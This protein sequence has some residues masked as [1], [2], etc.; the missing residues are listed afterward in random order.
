[1]ESVRDLHLETELL[2]I[3]YRGSSR[4]PGRF[5]ARET[6]RHMRKPSALPKLPAPGEL[7]DVGPANLVMPSNQEARV[8]FSYGGIEVRLQLLTRHHGYRVT[9]RRRG[10]A[11]EKP[12]E[13]PLGAFSPPFVITDGGHVLGSSPMKRDRRISLAPRRGYALRWA[14]EETSP[15]IMTADE[16]VLKLQRDPLRHLYEASVAAPPG[17]GTLDVYVGRM[18]A[19]IDGP[20]LEGGAPMRQVARVREPG[21]YLRLTSAGGSWQLKTLTLDRGRESLDIKGARMF[22]FVPLDGPSASFH[23]LTSEGLTYLAS[24]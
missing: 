24:S 11:L 9:M 22:A 16:A 19:G 6:Y 2:V 12:L 23:R 10:P 8:A 20:V 3:D 13:V 14:A 5:A 7:F 17:A 15:F 4:Y 18:S 21:T 1:M